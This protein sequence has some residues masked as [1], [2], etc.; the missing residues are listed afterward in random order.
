MEFPGYPMIPLGIHG[1]VTAD[2]INISNEEV[3]YF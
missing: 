3:N 1:V 2:I